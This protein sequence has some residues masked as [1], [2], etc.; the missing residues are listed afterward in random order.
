VMRVAANSASRTGLP[1]MRVKAYVPESAIAG[2]ARGFW[3]GLGGSDVGVTT[4]TAGAMVR[5]FLALRR[6]ASASIGMAITPANRH[7][8]AMRTGGNQ[9]CKEFKPDPK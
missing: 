8:K 2:A 1:P 3:T 6:A 4:R 7:T 5:A 9:G